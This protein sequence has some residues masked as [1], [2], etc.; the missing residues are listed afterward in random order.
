MLE[1][2]LDRAFVNN[3]Y[4]A[5]IEND[6]YADDF[7]KYFIRNL[8][9]FKLITNYSDIDE[10]MQQAKVNPLLELIIERIPVIEYQQNFDF[11]LD[12]PAFPQN[13]SPIKL[14]LSGDNNTQCINRRKRFGLEYI[15]PSNL[16]NRW[17]LYYSRRTDINKKTSNDSEIPAD[18]RFDSWDCIKP[19]VHPLNAIIIVDFYLLNWEREDEFTNNMNNN[20][21]PLLESMLVEASTDVPVN[22]SFIS[23]FKDRPPIKQAERVNISR[24]LLEAAIKKITTKPFNLNLIVHNKQNYPRDYQE[25]HDRI[26]ITNYFYINCGAGFNI[27]SKQSGIGIFSNTGKIGKIRHNSEIQFRSILNIQNYWTAF[28]D[29]KQLDIYCK[30]L[31]NHPGL[32]DYLN[33]SPDKKNRLMEIEHNNIN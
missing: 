6:E 12:S 28:K 8:Q 1:L 29:L 25:F 7:Y 16:K 23:E 31:D 18:F 33:F 2:V 27:G 22:I 21:V 9:K 32:P 5:F 19:F 11:L 26:I 10:L 14:V 17:P 24:Q 3:F 13:G 15:N 30:K 4:N 20:I